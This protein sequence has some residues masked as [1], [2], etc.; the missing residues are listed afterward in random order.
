MCKLRCSSRTRGLE[1]LSMYR[2]RFLMKWQFLMRFFSCAVCVALSLIAPLALPASAQTRQ[3]VLIHAGAAGS[4]YEI[5]ANEF[6]QRVNQRL[7][8]LYR[9]AI[10][11]DP[12]L[13]DSPALLDEVKNG[14]AAFALSSSGMI[15]ISDAF[16]I[17]ELP[18]LIRDRAQIRNAGA[19]LLENYLQPAAAKKGFQIL[20]MWENGFRQITNGVRRIAHPDDLL[21]LRLA[22]P[23][24]PWREKVVRAFGATPV[25]MASRALKEALRRRIADG[26]EAPLAEI[27]ALELAGVQ[28]HL[29]MSDH[30]YS[31]AFL[32]ASQAQLDNLPAPVR[33]IIAAEAL[34]MERRVANIAIEMES[35]LVDELDRVMAISHVD[36]EA[37]RAASRTVYGDFVRAVPGGAK[38]IEIVTSPRDITASGKTTQ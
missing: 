37:F 28:R 22:I 12:E 23:A 4:L 34:T 17:F 25:P 19:A 32:V 29:S 36:I 24:N 5:S 27:G 6:A 7:P 31:P 30:L 2:M 13:G 35:G 21:G 26:Q 33:A 1:A 18:F 15:S 14:G 11:S 3:L 10:T 16:G 8:G 9:I 20:A 38:M